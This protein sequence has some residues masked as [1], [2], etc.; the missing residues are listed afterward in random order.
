MKQRTAVGHAI[1]S[2]LGLIGLS[3]CLAKEVEDPCNASPTFERYAL[4][5]EAA[6]RQPYEEEV[7]V[8][9]SLLDRPPDGNKAAE[10]IVFEEYADLTSGSAGNFVDADSW[11][12]KALP[13]GELHLQTLEIYDA[14]CAPVSYEQFRFNYA[15]TTPAID[16]VPACG[17]SLS[18]IE[19]GH[20]FFQSAP[21]LFQ[22]EA[23]AYARLVGLQLNPAFGTSLRFTTEDAAHAGEKFPALTKIAV[24]RP[25]P[26]GLSFVA[27]LRANT[28]EGVMLAQLAPAAATELRVKL[29]LYPRVGA[30][31]DVRVGVLGMSSMFWKGA[32]DTPDVPDDEAHDTDHL[33]VRMADGEEKR[34]TLHNPSPSDV[35]TDDPWWRAQYT[36]ALETVALEQIQRDPTRYLAYRSASYASRPSM[37]ASRIESSVPITAELSIENTNSEYIDNLVLNL[38][39]ETNG[40]SEP[41][42]VSYVLTASSL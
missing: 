35:A 13:R 23:S 30:D 3:G 28:F 42:D 21:Q 8:P 27:R 41:V 20:S 29:R 17:H 19:I 6:A 1:L 34:V 37:S 31:R 40:G 25:T 33:Y 5:A 39:A 24:T 9:C 11:W 32:S 7:P 26:K 15:A 22:L 10:G 4:E 14:Q 16:P 18:A 12:V 38:I 36:G 2:T